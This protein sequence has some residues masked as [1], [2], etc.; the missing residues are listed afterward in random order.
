V[1]LP[2]ECDSRFGL[3][4]AGIGGSI[5]E[6]ALMSTSSMIANTAPLESPSSQ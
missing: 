2:G 4:A 1:D 6:A 5:G 3:G